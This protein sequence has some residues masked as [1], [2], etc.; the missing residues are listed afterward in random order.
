IVDLY[1]IG[2]SN[3]SHKSVP[4]VHAVELEGP[5]GEGV[6]T[7]GVFDDGAMVNA[8]D[9]D[10]FSRVKGRLSPLQPSELGLR[11]ADGRVVPSEGVWSG[12]ISVNGA[13]GHG[14]FEVFRS[15]NAWALLFGKPL[16]VEFKA[17]HDY[18]C[19]EIVFPTGTEP[20]RIRN[21]FG[22]NLHKEPL[23]GLTTNIEQ[24]E[25]LKGD[26]SAS[27]SRQV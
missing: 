22:N 12:F 13:W 1:G 20:V 2:N 4:F 15:G 24:R 16:L 3:R 7:K 9:L 6:Q 18:G 8:I 23:V 11:M 21:Q 27:P 14:D 19:D 10:V 17:I 26:S 25:E 5:K